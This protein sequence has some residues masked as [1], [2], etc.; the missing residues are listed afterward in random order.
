MPLSRPEPPV[1]SQPAVPSTAPAPIQPSKESKPQPKN[2]KYIF[3]VLGIILLILLVPLYLVLA[4][5]G[6]FLWK[7]ILGPHAK[8]W[9]MFVVSVSRYIPQS[10]SVVTGTYTS[11]T[12]LVKQAVLSKPGFLVLMSAKA[13]DNKYTLI[14]NS[15]WLPA[16]RIYGAPLILSTEAQTRVDVFHPGTKLFIGIYRDD[17][18]SVFDPLT[19][20]QAVGIWGIPIG[21]DIIVR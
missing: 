19:D 7:Q 13:S 3:W 12:P 14:G 5:D 15:D 18:D 11:G 16:G 8:S 21:R 20:T 10:D 4:G 2:S 17:G 9:D 6:G 1:N